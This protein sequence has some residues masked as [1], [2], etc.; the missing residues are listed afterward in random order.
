[1]TLTPIPIGTKQGHVRIDVRPKTENADSERKNGS[2]VPLNWEWEKNIVLSEELNNPK[3]TT[4]AEPASVQEEEDGLTSSKVTS[5]TRSVVDYT[6]KA[7]AVATTRPQPTPSPSPSPIPRPVI[8]QSVIAPEP[9]VQVYLP[10][11]VKNK[12]E[13]KKPVYVV[14]RDDKYYVTTTPGEE[15]NIVKS[16]TE[17]VV[18]YEDEDNIVNTTMYKNDG[19]NNI[20]EELKIGDEVM[21]DDV[22]YGFDKNGNFSGGGG[23]SPMRIAAAMFCVV[24]A[25]SGALLS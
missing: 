14:R 1:V 23:V 16:A 5:Y 13:A 19:T 15:D 9:P 7:W 18:E 17:I 4:P 22:K 2:F 12:M 21:L 25:L 11:A 24:F 8:K 6:P 20:H 3:P 10:T